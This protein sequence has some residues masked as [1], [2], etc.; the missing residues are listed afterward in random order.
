M[1]LERARQEL[2][3][4]ILPVEQIPA[5]ANY[6]SNVFKD[7]DLTFIGSENQVLASILPLM[8]LISERLSETL[9]GKGKQH[10]VDVKEN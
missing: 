3:K 4:E 7:A 2:R 6:L 5:I 8:Q 9:S 10:P 1:L